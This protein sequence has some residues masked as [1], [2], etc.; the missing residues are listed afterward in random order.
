MTE[1]KTLTELTKTP[2][3]LSAETPDETA[4]RYGIDTSVTKTDEDNR[5][6]EFSEADFMSQVPSG[7]HL[8]PD[9][10]KDLQ[11]RGIS[12]PTTDNAQIRK[13]DIFV[14]YDFADDPVVDEDEEEEADKKNDKDV[15]TP[16]KDSKV[17]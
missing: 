6:V 2:N 15:K 17:K 1:K 5:R 9:I 14:G 10:A 8:H 4:A 12:A 7:T 16:A 11:N 3:E 13:G